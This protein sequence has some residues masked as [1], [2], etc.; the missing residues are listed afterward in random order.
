MYRFFLT[1]LLTAALIT[2]CGSSKKMANPWPPDWFLNPPLDPNYVIST[3]MGES[4]NNQTAYEKADE[5][6][7]ADIARTLENRVTGLTKRFIED[8]EAGEQKE[9]TDMFTRV[10]KQ[11]VA[12]VLYGAMIEKKAQRF[13]EDKNVYEVCILK[14]MPIGVVQKEFINT[15]NDNKM[16]IA[17]FKESQAM[18]ELDDEVQ[19]FEDWKDKKN[20]DLRLFG[21]E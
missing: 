5:A 11:I 19:K 10:G 14:T 21:Q 6:A 3:A 13:L 17:K 15:I 12:N 9:Y 2:S 7:N 20:G 1:L 8:V 4:K 16:L 18:Q